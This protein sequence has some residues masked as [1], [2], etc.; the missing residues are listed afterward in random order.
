MDKNAIIFEIFPRK[1]VPD[2]QLSLQKDWDTGL[3]SR[4]LG[5]QGQKDQSSV[6]QML[7]FMQKHWHSKVECD[8]SG[9]EMPS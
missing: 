7:L 9:E 5:F 3:G 6:T 8:N 4:K 2:A 1:V